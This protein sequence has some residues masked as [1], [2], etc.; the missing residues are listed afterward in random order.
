MMVNL[1]ELDSEDMLLTE[2]A[3]ES[4]LFYSAM[5]IDNMENDESLY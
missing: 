1:Y 2:K 5:I 4:S 3:L